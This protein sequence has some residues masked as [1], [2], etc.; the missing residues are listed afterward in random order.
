MLICCDNEAKRSVI[1]VALPQRFSLKICVM[2][3]GICGAPGVEFVNRPANVMDAE[4]C[5]DD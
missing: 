2:E 3:G 4:C 1:N 5:N